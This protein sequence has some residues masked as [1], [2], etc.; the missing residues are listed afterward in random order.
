MSLQ[1]GCVNTPPQAFDIQLFAPGT[2][3]VCPSG[4]VAVTF[5]GALI[6]RGDTV[7]TV[8]LG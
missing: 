1:N 4:M 6:K 7:V 2:Q 3:Q 8:V 5:S